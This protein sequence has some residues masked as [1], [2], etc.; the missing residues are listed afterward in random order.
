[1][2]CHRLH[3]ESRGGSSGMIRPI[4]KYKSKSFV[5]PIL[6][7]NFAKR[8]VLGVD[9]EV[10]RPLYGADCYAYALLASGF[11]TDLVVEAFG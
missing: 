5:L 11:G 10:K 1:M 2:T 9:G 4:T 7:S 3:Q 8:P 6:L